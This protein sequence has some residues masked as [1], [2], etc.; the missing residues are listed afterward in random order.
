MWSHLRTLC[1]VLA[2]LTS[3]A[4]T[5]PHPPTQQ[6][7]PSSFSSDLDAH[8]SITPAL[9][10]SLEEFSRIVDIAYCVG[11]S[12][13]YAPFT[14]AGRCSDFPG[15]ELVDSWNTGPLMSD[16]CGYIAL[17]HPGKRIIVAFRGTYS[18]ANAIVDLSTVKQEYVPYPGKGGN[19]G[20]KGE[21]DT[22]G[23]HRHKCENCSVHSGFFTSW[24]NTR[25]EI[26]PHVSRARTVYPDYTLHIVGHSLGGAVAALAGIEFELLGW[27]PTITTFGEPRVGNRELRDW[28]DTLF[29]LSNATEMANGAGRYRRV[30][31]VDDPIPLLPLAEWGFRM[32]GGEM[33]ISKASLQP[34][35]DDVRICDGDEDPACIAGGDEPDAAAASPDVV[36]GYEASLEAQKWGLPT[37]YKMWQLFFAHRDYFWRLGLCAPGGDPWDWGRGKYGEDNGREGD[38][39]RGLAE[40]LEL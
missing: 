36:S 34:T 4:L 25:P 37:R 5:A 14:C 3:H 31:H 18:V 13:I 29:S 10:A 15:W 32:H 19:D 27:H 1:I 24:Q 7:L 38:E 21:R 6:A 16:S 40:A 23:L 33:F 9:F 39:G 20:R 28:L 22:D 12:G 26:V 11:V 30:T 35:V 2:G 17:D 8:R